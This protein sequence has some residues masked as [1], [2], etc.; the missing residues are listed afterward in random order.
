MQAY[1]VTGAR[2]ALRAFPCAEE[3]PLPFWIDGLP[4]ARNS[5]A[6]NLGRQIEGIHV[7]DDTGQV[8]GHIYWASS[9]RAVVPYH[10]EDGVAVVRCESVQVQHQGRGYMRL[11]FE[12]FADTL[13]DEGYKGIVVAGT[14]IDEYM[15]HRHFE[16]RG[17]RP[18]GI[19]GLLYLPL[20]QEAICV[21]PL[22]RRVGY[23]G[24]APV[25]VLII[26]SL[27]CPVGASAVL[28]IRRVAKELGDLVQLREVPA[29]REALS[30]YGVADGIF[31][32]GRAK[33]FGPVNEEQVRVSICEELPPDVR[34]RG[35]CATLAM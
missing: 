19:G 34:S 6:E 32:N 14:D 24:T 17:F 27:F 29:G 10:I 28:T 22:T 20:G 35:A 5:F 7:E 16:R 31:I 4:L 30:R 12:A 13:R 23:E 2:E 11:L 9:D 8:V 18:L 15:H 25:E 3:A 21:E 26:G 33:F 1:R